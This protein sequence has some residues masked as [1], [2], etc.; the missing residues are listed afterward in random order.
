MEHTSDD[1]HYITRKALRARYGGISEMT[2]WRWERDE[3][4]GFPKPTEINHRKYY[5]LTE[6]VNWERERASV[7]RQSEA[8]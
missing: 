7:I 5:D 1:K 3:R 4:L 2:I 6:I 8:A